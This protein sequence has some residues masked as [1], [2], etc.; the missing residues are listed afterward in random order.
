MRKVIEYTNE[1]RRVMALR[2]A[3]LLNEIE[4]LSILGT[5][6][7]HPN[8]EAIAKEV[9]D[10][11]ADRALLNI[12]VLSRTQS[13]KT[14]SMGAVIKKYLETPQN[15]IP[16]ENIYIITGHSS[17]EWKN[18]TTERM[19]DALFRRVFHRAELP[20]TFATEIR[21]KRNV[22]IIMD[23][24]QIAA[25]VNQT[26][27]K[28]FKACG[29]MDKDSL[30]ARDVKI[31]EYTATPDGT[32]YDL[33]RWEGGA[34]KKI[35][36]P[37]GAGYTSSADLLAQERVFQY[38]DVCG[39][40]T[41]GAA[42][43]SQVL[44]SI[45]KIR[46]HIE[47]Y[48]T[49]RYHIVRTRTGAAHDATKANFK[50][51]FGEERFGYYSYHLQGDIDN[52]NEV[53]ASP[54]E[55]HTFIFIM[56]MLRCSKTLRKD[57]LG[58]L[59]ER[60]TVTT[61]DAV[62]IQ[63]LLGRCT[64]YDD[65]GDTV[66]FTNIA[67]IYKYEALW[68]SAFDDDSVRWMSKTTKN[69]KGILEGFQ[70]FNDKAFYN[71]AVQVPR[72]PPP[73]LEEPVVV[74]FPTR[75]EAVE[76]FQTTL[77]PIFGGRGPSASRAQ[78]DEGFYTMQ[79]QGN[80]KVMSCADVFTIT[81]NVSVSEPIDTVKHLIQ[82]V[83]G[84]PHEHI[85]LIFAGKHIRSGDTLWDYNIPKESTLHMVLALLGGMQIF[86]KTLTGKT[87]LL[88][89]LASDSV[90]NVKSKIH[91]KEGIPPGQQRIM[92][93][94]KQLEDGY[95]LS[96]YNIHKESTLHLALQLRG[97]MR[98]AS[99]CSG[100]SEDSAIVPTAAAVAAPPTPTATAVAR[101]GHKK[102]PASSPAAVA[103]CSHKKRHALSPAASATAK[104]AR[105]SALAAAA[106]ATAAAAATAAAVAATAARAAAA[107]AAA[108]L[109]ATISWEESA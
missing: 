89:V 19:P 13:G 12:M 85:R 87:M 49:A 95:K 30:Y 109:V 103:Q 57:H 48:P 26:L 27:Y 60:Y 7:I 100:Y 25:Q 6:V 101:R 88:D 77:R 43:S 83:E 78:N 8:Q 75:E 70:T 5:S 2:R 97:G 41:G 93:A 18:Q 14:G 38:E 61:D 72:P 71:G 64:G 21:Q 82:D 80:R 20:T 106:E 68:A 94:G 28:T 33:V 81:L 65:P 98:G 63:G 90:D 52:I 108:A 11:F 54:P 10:S 96:D 69:R 34:S 32:I 39:F 16:V 79:H 66:I 86:V 73:P 40:E 9:V 4:V 44:E 29:L 46:P 17:I 22:L 24:I 50:A 51:V 47:R 37:A 104:A 3:N 62:V 36:A 15:L 23:E 92:F 58:V 74:K 45:E 107:A 91:D 31:V 59:Y 105:T 55:R 76:Y 35:M 56:E 42:A 67:S 53:L 102:R 84:I 1:E 99:S